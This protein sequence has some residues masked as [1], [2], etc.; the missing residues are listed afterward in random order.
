[1]MNNVPGCPH[2]QRG[3]RASQ[4][5]QKRLWPGGLVTY[6]VSADFGEGEKAMIRNAL[7][8]LQTKM[9]SCI[10]FKEATTGYRIQVIRSSDPCCSKSYVGYTAPELLDGVQLLL[11]GHHPNPIIWHEFLHAVGLWHTQTRSDRDNYVKIIWD[12]IFSQEVQKN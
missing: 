3:G 11:L 5:L 4:N 12:N 2:K 8:Q 6:E 10:R 9:D 7:L 1:M